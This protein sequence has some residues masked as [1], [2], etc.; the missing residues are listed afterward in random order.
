MVLG[1]PRDVQASQGESSDMILLR[2]QLQASQASC[3]R[4][5]GQLVD[6]AAEVD[7]LQERVRAGQRSEDA[8]RRQLDRVKLRAMAPHDGAPAVSISAGASPG[9]VRVDRV[10]LMSPQMQRAVLAAPAPATPGVPLTTMRSMSSDA[11]AA[12]PVTTTTLRTVSGSHGD[13]TP[14]H[15]AS[16]S[17]AAT[18]LPAAT[19]FTAA[20]PFATPMTTLRPV[21]ADS[22]AGTSPGAGEGVWERRCRE[23]Q[24]RALAAEARVEAMKPPEDSEVVVKVLPSCHVHVC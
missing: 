1:T 3:A 17:A 11:V 2:Q 16:L 21:T 10:Q 5:Q 8:A 19:P 7:A 24:E 15:M 9:P 22:T 4:L 13:A 6:S 12:T 18:P 23:M 20:T 14:V